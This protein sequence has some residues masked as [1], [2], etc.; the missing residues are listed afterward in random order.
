VIPRG[1]GAR[2]MASERDTLRL[3]RNPRHTI[4]P[5]IVEGIV[6]GM[7][8]VSNE[9]YAQSPS[10]NEPGLSALDNI[11]VTV[12]DE[13]EKEAPQ[14]SI[15]A[16]FFPGLIMFALMSLSIHVEYRFMQDRTHHVND[17]I[18]TA[19]IAPWRVVLEQR[20]FA[21]SF[22]YLMGIVS[23]L[24]GAVIWRIPAGGL[25]TANVL[26]VALA[27]FIAGWN[28]AV[29]A[30]GR[31]L[32]AASAIASSAMVFLAILGG[33]FFPA[34]FMP[35]AFQSF[36]RWVPTGMANIGLTHAL[37]GRDL[38]ISIP[39]LFTM[40]LAFVGVAVVLARRRIR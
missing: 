26:V 17:R 22:L 24:V 15:A 28:G 10:A 14:F 34:E 19:P 16:L 23:L 36:V 31:S 38:P 9:M 12:V 20:T 25:L 29:F 2:W 21:V 27:L 7:V 5:Q 32:R 1:F 30:L 3:Y 8:L 37:T 13:D 35:D 11:H 4:G 33:G 6:R 39:L 18:V 40:S